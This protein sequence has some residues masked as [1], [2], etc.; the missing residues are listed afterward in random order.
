[1]LS[2]TYVSS[3]TTL[4]DAARLVDLLGKI[5]PRNEEAGLTGLLLYSG[6]NIIQTIE[7]PD[8]VV[9]ATFAAIE[10]DPLHRGVMVVLR[11]PIAE[12]DFPD[13]SMGFREV[14]ADDLEGVDGFSDFLRRRGGDSGNEAPPA[15]RMLELFRENMR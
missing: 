9:D 2:L 3:A 12:R 14:S 13:W 7:G 5:R 10:H 6:G 8:D 15:Q 4:L 11:E 1:M